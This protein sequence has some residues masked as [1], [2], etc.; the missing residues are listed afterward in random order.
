MVILFSLSLFSAS[1]YVSLKG[2][3][4]NN[5]DKAA[6]FRTIK[7]GV[8]I[9][10]AGDTLMVLPGNY[11]YEY[12]IQITRSGTK[13]NPI[14]V[15]AEKGGNV[16]LNGPRKANE[17]ERA[18]LGDE[19]GA[20]FNNLNVSNIIINGFKI[21]NYSVG[22]ANIG[23][24]EK[25]K[26]I[27]IKNCELHNNA[28]DGIENYKVNNVLVSNCTFIS[29][30]FPDRRGWN[31]IQD[32]GVNFYYC[33]N[34]V[35][36]YSYFYGEHNQ[37]VSFKE[38]DTAGVIRKNIFEGVGH[39]AIIL[40]QNRISTESENNSNPSCKNLIAEYNII[41]PTNGLNQVE[42]K[43][44]YRTKTPILVDNVENAIVRYN[45]IEGFDDGNKT[46]GINLYNEARGKIEIYNNIVAFGVDNLMSGGIFQDWGFENKNDVEIHHNTFYKVSTDF[47]N[48]RHESDIIWHF[49]KNLAWK[50]PFYKSNTDFEYN[51]ENFRNNPEFINGDPRQQALSD[52]PVKQDF[53][54]YY[55]KLTEPFC[56]KKNSNAKGFGAKP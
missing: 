34:G 33:N 22:I 25:Q 9:L 19:K 5:G 3:D 4:S 41:R 12:N 52:S 55:K 6:P 23:V 45:Y 17:V 10:K 43:R 15:M 24:D 26:N 48:L 21:S 2:N 20:C 1:Y 56:L 29:D 46:C 30:E 28:S 38:G 16:I 53:D 40:G 8:K 27:T 37:C 44:K 42:P 54:F 35:V 14:V 13:E 49:T 32:Y 36:E 39:F 18:D 47:I 50:T 51:T 11:G 7:R 31:A